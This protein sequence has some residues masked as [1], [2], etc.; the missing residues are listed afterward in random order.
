MYSEEIYEKLLD[1]IPAKELLA[2][3]GLREELGW[4]Y[5][6]RLLA[7]KEEAD[8]NPTFTKEDVLDCLNSV[9][10]NPLLVESSR[11]IK[12]FEDRTNGVPV[13]LNTNQFNEEDLFNLA[14]FVTDYPS[15]KYIDATELW[16]GRR[17]N[18]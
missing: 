9:L 1:E 3:P 16:L 14:E 11:L 4:N 5:G 2:L 10:G 13:Q 7:L 8:K 6:M 17:K 15:K 18:G 12:W